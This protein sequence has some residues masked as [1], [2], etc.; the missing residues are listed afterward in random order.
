MRLMKDSIKWFC[1]LSNGRT[2]YEDKNEYTI[3]K[4]GFS[5]WGRLLK[6]IEKEDLKI[7]SLGLY[8]D[9]G[10]RWNLPSAGTNPRFSAFD[11]AE[12]PISYNFFRRLGVDIGEVRKEERFAVVE[13]IYRDRKLQLWVSENNPDN[14]WGLIV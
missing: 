13:A 6:N 9:N 7:T 8:M 3:V 14:C 5:P 4:G 11:L 12:K 10:R 1:S 2:Y